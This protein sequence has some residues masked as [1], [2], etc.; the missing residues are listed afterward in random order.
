MKKEDFLYL[1][2]TAEERTKYHGDWDTSPQ[3][4]FA[5]DFRYLF[6]VDKGEEYWGLPIPKPDD[7]IKEFILSL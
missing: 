6:G 4:W 2:G 7:R 3:E 1:H 5:E